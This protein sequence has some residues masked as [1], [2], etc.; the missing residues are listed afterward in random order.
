MDL[1]FGFYQ[2]GRRNARIN[3][4]CGAGHTGGP[5]RAESPTSPEPRATPW[6]NVRTTPSP[7]KGIS[8]KQQV[9]PCFCPYRAKGFIPWYPGRC[10]GLGTGCPFRALAAQVRI[11]RIFA[12]GLQG[13]PA[14]AESPTSSEPRATPWVPGYKAL[15]PVRAKVWA[16]GCLLLLP[17]QGA[18]AVRTLTQGV[19]LGSELVGL[20]ARA[21]PPQLSP[22]AP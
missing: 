4:I 15:R 8:N 9:R 21:G 11:N 5:A 20:S 16:N 1:Q 12:T 3:R 18:G 10:P 6:V 7:C 2:D 22:R 14:R 17:L 13:G 19:A